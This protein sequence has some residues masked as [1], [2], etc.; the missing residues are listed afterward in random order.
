MDGNVLSIHLEYEYIHIID[1]KNTLEGQLY[2]NFFMKLR[3]YI[4]YCNNSKIL[5]LNQLYIFR[6]LLYLFTDLLC[7]LQLSDI[8]AN[9]IHSAVLVKKVN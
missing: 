9:V 3:V 5:S 1:S 6:E 8:F 4:F 7:V 2:K